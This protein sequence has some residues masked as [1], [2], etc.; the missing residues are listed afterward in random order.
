VDAD[1]KA[2]L[3]FPRK[4]ASAVLGSEETAAA[5]EYC[6]GYIEF[7]N[8][9]KTEREAIRWTVTQAEARGFVPW[10]RGMPVHW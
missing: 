5:D 7:L 2:K 8:A 1:L 9:V 6:K 4:N 3:L 10:T